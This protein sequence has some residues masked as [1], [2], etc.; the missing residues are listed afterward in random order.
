LQHVKVN[1]LHVK[2]NLGVQ[3]HFF[4]ECCLADTGGE[5]CD[6][7]S[8]RLGSN[9]DMTMAA[10]KVLAVGCVSL[11]LLGAALCAAA[12]AAAGD[13]D[14]CREGEGEAQIAAC[15]G[16][17]ADSALPN[18]IRTEALLRHSL[19]VRKTG[20][21][22]LAQKAL[23]A[24]EEIDPKNG[25]V[26][27]AFAKFHYDNARYDE[28]AKHIMRAQGLLPNR[29]E[30]H[31]IMGKIWMMRDDLDRAIKEFKTAMAIDPKHANSRLNCANAYYKQGRFNEA[32]EQYII[33]GRLYP[34]GRLRTNAQIMEVIT[35][36][37]LAGGP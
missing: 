18:A 17:G 35:R 20:D 28:A 13:L 22:A 1:D 37:K 29:P 26:A 15:A 11:T 36:Q 3:I 9:R 5:C 6:R 19:L 8:A 12:G 21:D 27:I 34:E 4:N 32:L 30:P 31:N 10:N 25:D 7:G 33:A 14:Q 24:A 16:V 23:E 2:A